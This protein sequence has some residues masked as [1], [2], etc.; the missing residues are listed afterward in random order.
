MGELT[1]HSLFSSLSPLNVWPGSGQGPHLSLCFLPSSASSEPKTH[2]TPHSQFISHYSFTV[3][4]EICQGTS[5][6]AT[7]SN[8]P[9]SDMACWC[10]FTYW[11]VPTSGSDMNFPSHGGLHLS[12]LTMIPDQITVGWPSKRDGSFRSGRPRR[13][14]ASSPIPSTREH[15][16]SRPFGS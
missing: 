2:H 8:A 12:Q 13:K 14:Y 6:D 10:R 15:V 9:P 1:P 3:S 11:P 5:I 16:L 4:P 7:N